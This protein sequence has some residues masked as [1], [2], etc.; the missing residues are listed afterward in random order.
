[1]TTIPRPACPD[2]FPSQLSGPPDDQQSG[3]VRRNRPDITTFRCVWARCTAGFKEAGK[4]LA[5]QRLR[6]PPAFHRLRLS[7]RRSKSKSSSTLVADMDH[8]AKI[9]RLAG[10]PRPARRLFPS[11]PDGIARMEHLPTVEASIR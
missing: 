7:S 8:V 11:S 6:S 10:C 5:W 4:P 1:M 9:V 2:V 3:R